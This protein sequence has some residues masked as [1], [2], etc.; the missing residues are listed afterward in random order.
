MSSDRASRVPR[1]ASE[2]TYEVT[3]YAVN[4]RTR[5]RWFATRADVLAF[6]RSLGPEVADVSAVDVE[7]ETVE[8]WTRDARGLRY[9]GRVEGDVAWSWCE[10]HERH[11]I[12]AS[13]DDAFAFLTGCECERAKG[14][15]T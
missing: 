3:T 12:Y 8:A 9:V 4:G 1:V 2:H 7:R 11:T 5:D 10:T 15:A 14:G 13:S 6:V